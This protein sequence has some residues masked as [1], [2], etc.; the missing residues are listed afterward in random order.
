MK[1]RYFFLCLALA[2]SFSSCDTLKKIFTSDLEDE[3]FIIGQLY[4]D[5]IVDEKPYI[6]AR[7]NRT[8]NNS[9]TNLGVNIT[10]PKLASVIESWYGVPYKYGGCDKNGVD[11]SCFVGNVYK[12]V[13][14]IT[15]KRTANDIYQQCTPVA[16][17]KLTEGNLVFFTNS[18]GKISHV[19]IYLT[20]NTFVHSSTSHGVSFS[21]LTDSYWSKHFY[22]GGKVK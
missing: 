9:S 16:Q 15:L 18:N 5:E 1:T 8:T 19:G 7:P 22:K 20:D 21:K 2:M 13:Y 10:N 3:D 12:S 4:A 14:Q 6:P 11:C 17:N